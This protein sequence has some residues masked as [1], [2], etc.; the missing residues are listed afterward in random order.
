M[1]LSAE[2]DPARDVG[3]PTLSSTSPAARMKALRGV[4]VSGG[5]VMAER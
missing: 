5:E 2:V 4:G 1:M 3:G